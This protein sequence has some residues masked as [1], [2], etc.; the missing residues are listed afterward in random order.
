MKGYISVNDNRTYHLKQI[1]IQHGYEITDYQ[2]NLDFYYIDH[3]YQPNAHYVFSLNDNQAKFVINDAPDFRHFNNTLTV[4]GFL[5]AIKRPLINQKILILGFGDLAK[6]LARILKIN[7]I[8]TIA[9]RNYKDLK[10][11]KKD[12]QHMD[13]HLMTGKFDYIINTVPK[14]DID[15]EDLQYRKIY[16]LANSLNKERYESLRKLPNRYFPYE[17]AWL[18][19]QFMN[20]VLKHDQG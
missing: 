1:F 10:L 12:Y 19:F 13:I 16:D 15:Y 17:S 5:A 9:N 18:M 6:Q 7:N 20:E 14:K 8:I 3:D 2:D 11:I 4:A